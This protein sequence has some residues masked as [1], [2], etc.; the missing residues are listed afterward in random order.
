MDDPG[1]S[2]GRRPGSRRS[3]RPAVPD[4]L[5]DSHRFCSRCG[6]GLELSEVDGDLRERLVC[7]VCG[8]IAYINPRLVV[9]TLPVTDEGEVVLLR[10]GIDPG[11]GA[12]AQPG[13]FLEIDETAIE[14]A[15]RETLEETGL[16][17]EPTSIVGVYSRPQAAIVVVTYEARIVAGEARPTPEALEVTAFAPD[18]IP[19]PLI[20]FNTTTWALRDWVRSRGLTHPDIDLPEP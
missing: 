15:R 6:Q 5:R 14:G 1:A 17:V 7:P 18:A 9:T 13:G 11:Y 20:A 10:R 19:W 16:V 2:A 12:W 8:F 4:W 3:A